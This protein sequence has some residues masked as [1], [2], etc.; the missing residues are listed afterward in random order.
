[1]FNFLTQTSRCVL[2]LYFFTLVLNFICIGINPYI[3]GLETS[4]I[5]INRILHYC[6]YIPL[7]PKHCLIK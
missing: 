7:N 3:S 5:L 6:Q 4:L 1:M 2:V